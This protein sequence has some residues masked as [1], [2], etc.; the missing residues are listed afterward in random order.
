MVLVPFGL[1]KAKKT[2]DPGE[3]GASVL[4]S[5]GPAAVDS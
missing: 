1:L 2:H 4:S 3:G 5:N